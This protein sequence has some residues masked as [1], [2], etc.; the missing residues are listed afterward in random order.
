MVGKIG[1]YVDL[2]QRANW[3]TFL[4]HDH[5]LDFELGHAQQGVEYIII[6]VNRDQRKLRPF[7]QLLAGGCACNHDVT[8]RGLGK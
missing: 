5:A 7:V 1:Q 8:E 3:L 2:L 6:N 4:G